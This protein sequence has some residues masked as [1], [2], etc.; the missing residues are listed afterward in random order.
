MMVDTQLYSRVYSQRR[1]QGIEKRY[2]SFIL[3]K[4]LDDHGTIEDHELIGR[5]LFRIEN[6][7]VY[8]IKTVSLHW[9]EGW[10]FQLIALDS[11]GSSVILTLANVNST[12]EIILNDLERFE[13]EYEFL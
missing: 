7:E 9:Y 5:K 1:T 11:K 8:T 4:F 13:T 2:Y 3:N 10:Y 12:S 6:K